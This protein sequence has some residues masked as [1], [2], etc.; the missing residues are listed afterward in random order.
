MEIPLNN[1]Q[2][3]IIRR[4]HQALEQHLKEGSRKRKKKQK[5]SK[6]VTFKNKFTKKFQVACKEI[7]IYES[8]VTK[9]HCLRHT[10]AVMRYLETRDLYQVCK[11]LNHTS[12]TT[13]EIYAQFS[14]KR[15]EQDFAIKDTTGS[16][17]SSEKCDLDT[18]NVDT[19]SYI[20]YNSRLLN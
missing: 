8:R 20:N 13:T 4:I 9:L 17:M 7:G 5:G 11:E 1:W 3:A 19:Q 16:D 12:I 6:M 15:L 14:F 2:V 10:F 18:Q